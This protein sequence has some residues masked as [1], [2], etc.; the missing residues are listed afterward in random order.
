M[1]RI[2]RINERDAADGLY[3]MFLHMF[4]RRAF[5]ELHAGSQT[6]FVPNWHI[7]AMCHQLEMVYAG[8]NPRLVI[9][10]PPRHL[11]SITV[12]V[13]FVA[14]QLGQE[15]FTRIIVAS[16]G[17][18][19]VR[20]HA[21][22]C[23]QVMESAWYRRLFP[24]TRLTNRG[25]TLE[26]FNTTRGGGRKGVSTG[27]AVTGHG[28]DIVIIDDLLKASDASSETE[29][30]RAQT[31]IETSLLTRF[32]D[33]ARGKVIAIQQRLHEVDPAG[34][35]I[36]KGYRH[37][38][39]KAIAEGDETHALSPDRVHHRAQGGA[40]FPQRMDLTELERMRREMGSAN[41]NMQYQQNPIAPD[42]SALRWEWFGTYEEVLRPKCY[43]LIVQS[44]D[45]GTSADPRSDCSVCTTWG[46]RENKWSLLDTYRDR[47]DFPDLR[48]KALELAERWHPDKVLIEDA[49]SGRPLLHECRERSRSHF[50]GITPDRDKPVRF[51]AACARVE[52]GKVLLPRHATWLD[53]FRRELLGFP[54]AL[55]DDQV[56]SF[57]QFLNWSSS[58]G[59]WRTLPREHELHVARREEQ[60]QRRHEA[61]SRRSRR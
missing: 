41:F 28:A 55:R 8:T 11:K 51:N 20:K 60:I 19:L 15:P 53:G 38:N 10:V 59:F 6:Q 13:A 52:E 49:S 57:S 23:R 3:R 27:G 45:T 44:W 39:L 2:D 24:E 47:L 12:A 29:L 34:Y 43:Q 22:D 31:Y 32:N 58:L 26:E 50:I 36:D 5:A 25:N 56:D 9:T 18:D 37:L 17:L 40:L 61:K 30:L 42:G 1:T 35:L 54:R 7:E 46:F 21:A 48:R 14:W 16:Y 33:P 4:V